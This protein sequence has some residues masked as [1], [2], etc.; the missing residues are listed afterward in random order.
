[1]RQRGGR[2]RERGGRCQGDPAHAEGLASLA[3]RWS[4][5][6]SS[7]FVP[8]GSPAIHHHGAEVVCTSDARWEKKKR[9][10]KKHNVWTIC[11]L[12]LLER[13]T[14]VGEA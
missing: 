11:W 12:D 2:Q 10:K 4:A 5:V 3:D 14:E 1:M 8:L 7:Q 13:G 9:K 6:L